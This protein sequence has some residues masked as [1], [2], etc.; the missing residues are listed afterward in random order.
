MPKEII[1]VFTSCYSFKSL[2]RI[3]PSKEGEA[4]LSIYNIAKENNLSK[5]VLL[6]ENMTSFMEAIKTL[7]KE[8]QLIYGLRINFLHNEEDK[9]SKIC[10][11]AKDS[12]G[13]F[14]LM[15]I[16]SKSQ[17]K[18][19]EKGLTEDELRKG[20]TEKLLLTV[21][22]YDSFINKNLVSFSNLTFPMDLNPV[23]FIENNKLFLDKRLS[24]V[25]KGLAEE[26][27]CETFNAKSIFYKSA[28]DFDAYVTYR[29]ITGRRFGSKSTLATPNMEGM[30]SNLFS[31]ESWKKDISK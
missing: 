14:D 7:G 13:Y 21:P 9:I 27:K 30:A 31:I 29:C 10:I 12:D 26:Y 23:F 4:T 25:V 15:R 20:M 3:K 22:F 1:P 24:E 16:Y 11:F 28:E 5:I 17:T 6:E 8:F 19:G 18:D 2:L